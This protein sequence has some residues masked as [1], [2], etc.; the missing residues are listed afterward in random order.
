MT[1]KTGDGQSGG[2]AGRKGVPTTAARASDSVLHA[3]PEDVFDSCRNLRDPF[4]DTRFE[5]ESCRGPACRVFKHGIAGLDDL[6]VRYGSVRE[7]VKPND[8]P[9][10]QARLQRTRW[11][12]G[13]RTYEG[14]QWSVLYQ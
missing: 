6:D 8:Y 4:N 5:A 3:I 2:P 7:N 12:G 13:M 9:A 14:H 10:F 1:V 11:I